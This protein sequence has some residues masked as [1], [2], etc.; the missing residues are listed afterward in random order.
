MTRELRYD[1]RVVVVTGA[2]AGLGRE[3][4]LMF[5]A[6]GAKVVVNDLGG[7]IAGGGKSSAAADAV[8]EAI[9]ELGGEAV[10]NHDSVEDG[11]RI[12]QT[13]LDAFGTVDVIVNNAGILRDTSF[14]KM[15]D[16]DW[17]IIQRV[18]LTGS[19][20]VT[21]AA[22]PILRD[23][24]YG[25]IIMTT[26]AAGI[27]GNFG[28]A[29]YAA[30][31][32]GLLGLA[33]TLAEEGRSKNIHV[34]TIAPIAASRLTETAFSEEFLD[35]LRPEA[36]SPL[37]GW[38][39][40]EDCAET[41]GLFEIGAG[42]ISKLRWER[43][44]GHYFGADRLFTPDDV[45]HA[46]D[47]ITDFT[48]A[49][50]PTTI[51][52]SFE[53]VTRA[54]KIKAPRGNRFIDIDEGMRSPLT[55]ESAYD[56]RDLALYALGIG[57]ARDP[58]DDGERR[59]VYEQGE[60]SVLPTWGVMPQSNAMLAAAKDG[61]LTLPGANFGF[62]RLLHGEQF[63]EIR[64]PLPRAAKLRHIFTLKQAYDKDPHAVLVF[65]V[66]TVDEHG[67]E[68]VYNEMGA[69]VKGAGGWGGE[70]GP[71]ADINTPPDREPDAVIEEQTDAN[72]NLLYRLSGDWNPLHV[73]PGFAKAFGYDRP[74]LHGLCTYGHVG[75]HV[76]KA[77][78]GN[79][80][81]RFKNIKVRF[82]EPVFPGETI[83]TRM[84]RDGDNRVI[85]ESSVKERGKVVIRNAAVEF[86]DAVPTA[87][88][89]EEQEKIA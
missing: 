73:D 79:D 86:F 45:A 20:A 57:A 22:W 82:A 55:F 8:V 9:R 38:L 78:L 56:E 31:K 68:I 23:K 88:A 36:V 3:H 64:A 48:D 60:F 16:A 42:Y 69:F 52:D 5:G 13:A 54:V 6:R 70:R 89:T 67:T 25:R 2:G 24:S 77:M 12:I 61:K 62:D 11:Q 10:A 87:P 17:D 80:P 29:N 14:H 7:D 43:S 46:W 71:S 40:H 44:R 53:A 50:H 34:N 4:A 84:W 18:H 74:I 65:A 81:A 26:S 28:Q 75:R 51:N 72:Q 21:R 37:V 30:A 1:G 63:T 47:R 39:T 33:N 66:S 59:F 27:Y 35:G 83:V 49:E 85:V 41:K 58:M 19:Q 32:L 15:T 76:V